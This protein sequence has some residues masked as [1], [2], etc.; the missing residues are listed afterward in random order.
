[1]SEN[2]PTHVGYIVDGNR[3]WARAQGLK[4]LD[5]H[6]RGFEV[7]KDIAEVTFERGVKYVSAYIFSTENWR[8]SAEEVSYLMK[9]FENF[10]DKEIKKLHEK[11]VRVVFSGNR[12]KYVSPKIVELIER[13]EDLTKDNTAGTLCLCFNYG[14]QLEI[15]EA[16]QKIVA[17][18]AAGELRAESI[19]EEIFAQ[20]LYN[21]EV[22]PIDLMVRTS[23][24]QRI[25]N[26]QLWRVAYSEMI[27]LDKAW[28]D[29]TSDDVENVLAQYA[30]RDRRMGGDSK[31]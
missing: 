9:L 29:M 30:N 25:S 24:E 13:G 22:P 18:V 3:R 14:G 21:P 5:G 11:N 31:K 16:T 23:G 12:T 26:F 7:F 6:K 27:F 8:R 28:P 20:Y 4:S 2:L 17:K 15:V 19:T 10:F 1:M